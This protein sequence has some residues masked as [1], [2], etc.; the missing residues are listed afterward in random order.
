LNTAVPASALRKPRV[1]LLVDETVVGSTVATAT[2]DDARVESV[3]PWESLSE[4]ITGVALSSPILACDVTLVEDEIAMAP[5]VAARGAVKIATTA[6][7]MRDVW[8]RFMAGAVP[9]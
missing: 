9:E 6:V 3:V 4:S 2:A 7:K 5:A 1:E 8:S